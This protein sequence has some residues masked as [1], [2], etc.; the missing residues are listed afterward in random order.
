MSKPVKVLFVV[1]RFAAQEM[2]S[3][4]VLSA[5]IKQAGHAV[6]LIE[7]GG[8]MRA[9]ISRIRDVAP[10]VIAYSIC[11]SEADRY[12]EI[13]RRL[14]KEL[15][16][17][18]VFGGPHP[19]FFP[20]FIEKEGV[21]SICRGEGD[22]VFPRFLDALG[23]ASIY[24]VPNFSFRVDG[25]IRHNPLADLVDDLD[26][27][28]FPDRDLIYAKSA[29][30][31]RSPVKAFYS[32]RGCPYNC[33]Y[34]FNHIY[35]ELYR[36]KGRI[37]GTKSVLRL[38]AE[39]KDV[40]S[41]YPLTFVKFND[42]V[43][44]VKPEW[45]REFAELYPREI[46]L[47]FTCLARPNMVTAEFARLVKK[48]GCFSVSTAIESGDEEI[49][50][51]LLN[52][53]ISDEQI[54]QACA[55]LKEQGIKIYALNIIGLPGESEEQMLKTLALNRT[56]GADYADA[57]IFQPYP[58]TQITEYCLKNGYLDRDNMTYDNLFS[59]TVLN[60][61]PAMKLRIQTLRSMFT[62]IVDHPWLLRWYPALSRLTFLHP[63]LNL[64]YRVYYGHYNHQRVL[65]GKIPLRVRLSGAFTV[66]FSK[67]RA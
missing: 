44:G 9:A 2:I 56:V 34:C 11:S 14:K 48:A 42:D 57:T 66:L 29:F 17:H 63:L 1:D 3:V 52:R 47:P 6:D 23:T 18:A 10:E 26:A 15:R 31:A 24:D 61:P 36:G 54:I 8:D 27:L 46:G 45:L 16:F 7:I 20:S 25:S 33:S 37:I 30:Q 65:A 22:L 28:P 32:G 13:N 35:H 19:T 5:V 53:R 39:I 59:T 40:A 60:F 62:M 4:P 51:T 41:R 49:R 67:N 58:G 50:R 21:D 38:L 12:L 55:H 64:V 43:F